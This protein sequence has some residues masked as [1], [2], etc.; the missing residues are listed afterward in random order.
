LRRRRFLVATRE[1]RESAKWSEGEIRGEEDG[2]NRE[3]QR[4]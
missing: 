3:F 4:Q 2:H 1:H